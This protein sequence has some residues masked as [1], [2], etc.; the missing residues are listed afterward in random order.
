LIFG[1]LTKKVERQVQELEGQ[2]TNRKLKALEVL[3]DISKD[4]PKFARPAIPAVVRVLGDDSSE[5]R[6]EALKL[7]KGLSKVKGYKKDILQSLFESLP[8]YK[9]NLIEALDIL[10]RLAPGSRDSIDKSIP[11]LVDMLESHDEAT[12]S[13]AAMVLE[14]FKIPANKY[15]SALVDA[16][17]VLD[18]AERCGADIAKAKYMLNAARTGMKKTFYD[19]VEKAI[20]LAKQ[21]ANDGRKTV[22]L[23]RATVPAAKAIDIAPGARNIV[24]CGSDKKLY[25]IDRSG[26][27]VWTKVLPDG[28]TCVALTLDESRILVGC[29]D[30]HLHCFSVKGE[31]LWKYRMSAQATSIAVSEAGNALVCGS[32]NNLYIIGPTGAMLA[33]HWTDRPGWRVGVSGD[34]EM[35]V[36]SYR[37]HNVYCYD[38]NLFLRWKYMGGIWN[39]VVI[40]RDGECVAAGSQG[41]DVLFFSK[42]GVVQ[43]KTRTD[44]PVAQLAISFGGEC[45]Y[46]TDARYIYAFNRSGKQLYKYNAR[47][48]LLAMTCDTSGE[49]LALVFNDRIILTRNREMVRQLVT[50]SQILLDNIQRL[51]VDV[52]RPTE[53]FA[54]ARSAFDANDLEKGTEF[55]SEAMRILDAEKGRRAEELTASIKVVVDEA[56]TVGADTSKSEGMLKAAHDSLRKGQLDRVLLLLGQAREEAEIARRVQEGMIMAEKEAKSGAARKA[57]Q[58]AIAMTDEAVEYGMEATQAEAILQ[59]AISATDAEDYDKAMAFLRQLEEHVKAERDRLPGRVAANFKAACE[60]LDNSAIT[61]DMI[62]KARAFLSGAIVFYDKTGDLRKLAETY[63]RLGFLEEKRGKIPY[64]KFLYQKAVNTY[65]KVGEIDQVLTLLVERLRRLEAITDKKLR[66][67]TIEE[68]FL[69]YRDGRLILH[70]TR[71]LRPDVDNDMLGSMLVAIQNFVQEGFRNKEI[72]I[73][74]E[75]RYGKTR[76]LIER[77]DY[78]Y[79]ALVITGEEPEE[80]REEMKKVLRDIEEKYKT[81]LASW[82]GDTS[83]LWGAKKMVDGILTG[84]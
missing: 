4:D 15:S 72:E 54:K 71:R 14:E 53:L 58:A 13:G 44:E 56:K 65:F 1:D 35:I 33:K 10:R 38:K 57:I 42:I 48:P 7:L 40:S 5:V 80:K 8:A 20:D 66:E 36:V 26:N 49:Y 2:L 51:G 83:K 27:I 41:N 84:I 6:A 46:I 16:K 29:A 25:Y 3:L 39:D 68:I 12:R 74:N 64:S 47:D 50:G 79:L 37:D 31:A 61:P 78:L 45:L 60:I 81:V 82:D 23:W 11:S 30:G 22:R 75:L 9:G 24:A 67:Y 34:G 52:Q 59:K 55:A 43:W 17:L 69:I 18:D 28:G 73:L 63:E 19:E 77:T 32:D 21:L 62:E 70:N 76:I